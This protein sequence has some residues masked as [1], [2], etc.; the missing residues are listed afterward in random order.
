MFKSYLTADHWT[1]SRELHHVLQS[2]GPYGKPLH[3][4]QDRAP[5]M[6]SLCVLQDQVPSLGGYSL[7]G[8]RCLSTKHKQSQL[9]GGP[10]KQKR[11]KPFKYTKT[12]I[13]TTNEHTQSLKLKQQTAATKYMNQTNFKIKVL[14]ITERR[15]LV[16]A[17]PGRYKKVIF[18]KAL[19]KQVF[20]I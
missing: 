10:A 18:S 7:N 14:H 20:S 12:Y 11:H 9:D 3:V 16:A 1:T 6:E 19:V 17:D 5:F 15:R 4:L 8:S 13:P 2:G